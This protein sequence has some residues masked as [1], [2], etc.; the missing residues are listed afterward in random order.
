MSADHASGLETQTGF[1][2][3]AR[4]A[5]VRRSALREILKVTEMP[6]IISFAGGLPA[7]ELF[8]VE[9][10]A[11]AAQAVFRDEGAAALQYSTS[12]GH[13]PLREWVCEYLLETAGLSLAPDQVLIVS[14]SQ[15][16]LDLIA[17]VLIDPGDSVVC[18]DP[19]Y[20]GALQAFRS[21]Q[22]HVIGLPA[23]SEG[24]RVDEL[25]SLL[26]G[27][28][29][30]P[31]LLY[32]VT[33]FQN[34]TG[35]TL[36]APRRREIAETA[37]EFGLPIL[38]DDPYCS[39]RYE[40]DRMPALAASPGA[41]DCLYL[42]TASKVLAPGLRVAWIAAPDR[43]VYERLVRAKQA[44]DLHTASFNQRMVAN[45]VRR[46]GVLAAHI[47]RLCRIYGER[48]Q[49]MLGALAR[50]LPP[51]SAWTHPRG[52]LFVWVRLPDTIDTETLLPE[53]LR[54]RVAFVPGASFWT[55]GD[56]RSTLRLNFSNASPA[57]IET[58]VR[59]L[60]E[61]IRCAHA[62]PSSGPEPVL[63]ARL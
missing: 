60:A 29:R 54:R 13:A 9:E 18:E 47:A 35:T 17:K 22:A 41:R 34:P 23:D 8:P 7:P 21:Y 50:E 5:G 42:G 24:L 4:T 43:G 32:L 30:R 28:A 1:R 11:D 44:C 27:A 48:R 3:A 57:R 46:P 25:R 6:E 49:A 62:Y 55:N 63:E 52:G 45:Y 36:S 59:R 51:G 37:A 10:L 40:G 26:R 16:G 56:V 53:A 33:N 15:Q 19:A 2:F 38:E 58:G 12:E 14:G 31:K 20:L 39:L 61:A